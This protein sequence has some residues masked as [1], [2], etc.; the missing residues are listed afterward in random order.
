MQEDFNVKDIYEVIPKE[1]IKSIF[2]GYNLDL[3]NGKSALFHWCRVMENA[4]VISEYNKANKKVIIAFS[5]FHKSKREN[6]EFDQNESKNSALFLEYFEEDINL[7]EEEFILAHKACLE[8]DLGL[9]PEDKTIAT[10]WDG[11]KLD[12]M[13]IGLYPDSKKMITDCAKN[14]GIIT[15]AMKRSLSQNISPWINELIKDI[16]DCS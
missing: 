16:N 6:E 7:T 12:S 13:R 2:N 10:C 4:L 1:V 9:I 3:I 15:W 11:E 8:Y 14:T 5:F